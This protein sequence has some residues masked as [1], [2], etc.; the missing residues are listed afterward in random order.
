M[1]GY[2][3]ASSLSHVYDC[4]GTYTVIVIA[5]NDAGVSESSIQIMVLGL[6]LLTNTFATLLYMYLKIHVG[7]QSNFQIFLSRQ[8][9]SS[10]FVYSLNRGTQTARKSAL[11]NLP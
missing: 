2:D 5:S 6:E 8:F 7:C 1:T 11:L 3:N 4:P 9:C 10:M